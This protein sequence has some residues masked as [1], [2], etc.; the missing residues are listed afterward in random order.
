MRISVLSS[1]S[2]QNCFYIETETEA[3]LVDSGLSYPKLTEYLGLIGRSAS[4]IRAVFITHEHTDH[5]RGL[6]TFSRKHAV[7]VYIHAD[8][9]SASGLKLRFPEALTPDV[10]V[11][12]ES[13]SVTPFPVSHDAAHTF[14]F[15][16]RDRAGG[17]LF[18]ASDLGKADSYTLSM[19]HGCRCIAVESNHD[20]RML[21][22]CRYPE[23]LKRRIRSHKGHL[24]NED[25]MS[26]LE[27]AVTDNTRL[28][29][30]LHLSDNAN[31]PGIVENCL[32]KRLV[33]QF[34]H[35]EFRVSS[36][37]HPL[38]LAGI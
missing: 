18:L 23:D 24:S 1:G 38:P 26:F 21:A 4:H 35:V 29:F 31:T 15:L 10:S 28:V 19:A 9:L 20:L 5:I 16:V 37:D 32:K 11:E 30:L 6:D 22:A 8:S 27:A 7:P 12:L 14:G 13:M 36:R 2:K 17:T 25:A 3:I 33:R 34:P